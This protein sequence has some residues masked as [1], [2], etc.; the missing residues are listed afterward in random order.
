[1]KLVLIFILIAGIITLVVFGIKKLASG[2]KVNHTLITYNGRTCSYWE[3]KLWPDEYIHGWMYRAAK[4]SSRVD[5]RTGT[6]QG[7]TPPQAAAIIDWIFENYPVTS[8]GASLS[9]IG[10]RSEDRENR[11]KT[12]TWRFSS[13]P[14]RGITAQAQQR[15]IDDILSE[16]KYIN[17]DKWPLKAEKFIDDNQERAKRIILEDLNKRGF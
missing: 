1:M 3:A 5:L 4:L 12:I 8:N 10:S 6:D 17:V 7:V 2:L 11:Q 14:S 9:G 15:L 16:Y 13:A